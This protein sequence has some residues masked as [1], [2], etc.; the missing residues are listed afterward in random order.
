MPSH[1]AVSPMERP[2]TEIAATT[3]RWPGESVASAWPISRSL[4]VSEAGSAKVS[5]IS[6]I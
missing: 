4:V 1:F 5:A 6:S 3:E 2:S